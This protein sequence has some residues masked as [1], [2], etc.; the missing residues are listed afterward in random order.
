MDLT[1]ANCRNFNPI[2]HYND[3]QKEWN[4]NLNNFDPVLNYYYNNTFRLPRRWEEV[5]MMDFE[6]YSLEELKDIE[7][8]IQ[9]QIDKKEAEEKTNKIN[10]YIRK[11]LPIPTLIVN[12]LEHENLMPHYKFISIR[13][14]FEENKNKLVGYYTE[15]IKGV[16]GICG[17]LKPLSERGNHP[18]ITFICEDEGDLKPIT[19][20]PTIIYFNGYTFK[21][22]DTCNPSK[23]DVII[24]QANIKAIV[25]KVDSHK[26][27]LN[28]EM[29]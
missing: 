26:I 20:H 23:D 18:I 6:N 13:D 17:K 1:C 16:A 12:N 29:L 4:I 25:I 21:C 15:S 27:K 5:N 24:H 2:Y 22:N 19:I 11:I 10:E 3:Y 28:L 9:T 8:K 7:R 14:I